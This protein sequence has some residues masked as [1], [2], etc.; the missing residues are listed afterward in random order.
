MYQKLANYYKYIFPSSRVQKD[1]FRNIFNDHGVKTV[2]DVA[3]GT[4]EQLEG[5][6]EMGFKV[7]GLELEEAMVELIREKPLCRSGDITVKSGNMLQ[8]SE[9]FPG[10]YDAVLCIGN[11]LV[12]LNGMEEISQVIKS[13]AGV[14]RPGGLV[15]IQIVNYDR[16]LD[17]QVTSLGPIETA[18]ENG[19]PITFERLYDLGTLPD[20]IQFN[21]TLSVGNHT[22]S[23]SIPLFPLR[24]NQLL[25]L[26]AEAGFINPRLLGGYDLSP[27]SHQ[28]EGCILAAVKKE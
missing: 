22:L 7:H 3:C 13:M 1:F 14:L 20:A 11:S 18:D 16:I 15:V 10:P 26:A 24:S 19:T 27:F 12:H 8:T 28:T 4:G 21:T 6:A 23:S 17:N 2:L 5:F 25:D 9:L